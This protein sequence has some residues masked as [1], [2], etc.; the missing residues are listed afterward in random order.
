MLEAKA[1]DQ[2]RR[3]K[4]SPKKVFKKIFQ[5]VSKNKKRS[6]K[7][8]FSRSLKEK[9]KK[10]LRNIFARFLALSIKTLTIQKQCRPRAEDRAIFEDLRL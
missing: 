6:S 8:F 3:R 4:C 9:N 5:A 2:E 7:F 1:K 10:G